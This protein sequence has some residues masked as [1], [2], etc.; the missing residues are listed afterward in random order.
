MYVQDGGGA[1]SVSEVRGQGGAA[2]AGTTAGGQT[3]GADTPYT[4]QGIYT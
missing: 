1:A 2:G 3:D 4:T